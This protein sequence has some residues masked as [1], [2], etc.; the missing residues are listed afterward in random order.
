MEEEEGHSM[1]WMDGMVGVGGLPSL[2]A[3]P[4]GP[5]SPPTGRVPRCL[6][7]QS[8]VR[9]QGRARAPAITCRLPSPP[10]GIPPTLPRFPPSGQDLNRPPPKNLHPAK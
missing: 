10:G 3:D 5:G 7:F 9:T 1:R 2:V 4:D 6:P 8:C